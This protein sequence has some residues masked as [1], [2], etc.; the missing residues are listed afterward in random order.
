MQFYALRVQIV[1]NGRITLMLAIYLSL[2]ALKDLCFNV[3]GFRRK[4]G[5]E[6][7]WKSAVCLVVTPHPHPTCS[8]LLRRCKE[9]STDYCTVPRCHY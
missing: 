3:P 8:R 9:L 1:R 6:R 2:I 7:V 5:T 4:G